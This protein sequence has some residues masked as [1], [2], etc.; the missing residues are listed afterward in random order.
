[1]ICWARLSAVLFATRVE[2]PSTKIGESAIAVFI[3]RFDRVA[4]NF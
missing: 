4:I 3:D 1:M 2:L